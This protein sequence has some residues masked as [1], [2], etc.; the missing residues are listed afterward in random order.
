MCIVVFEEVREVMYFGNKFDREFY[1][2]CEHQPKGYDVPVKLNSYSHYWLFRRHSSKR[3]GNR[4]QAIP[5]VLFDTLYSSNR[6]DLNIEDK[7]LLCED[8]S[9]TTVRCEWTD[10]LLNEEEEDW[11]CDMGV[12]TI[13]GDLSGKE[14]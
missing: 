1:F 10:K 8:N 5:L 12:K 7:I 14:E 2:Q 3:Q 13:T 4:V 11:I 6:R 9:D